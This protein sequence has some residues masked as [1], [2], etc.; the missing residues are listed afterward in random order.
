M[1]NTFFEKSYTKCDG[2]TIPRPFSKKSKSSISR[3]QNSKVWY[4]LFLCMPSWGLSEHSET[5]LQTTC[6]YLPHIW[7]VFNVG[8]SPF[9][10]ICVIRLIESPLK[11]IKNAFYFTLKALFILKIFK[12]LS[13]L[14]GHISKWLD[15]QYAYW[16]CL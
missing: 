6:F 3:D 10:N 8:L 11:M 4:S 9:K 12:F 16:N 2:D 15:Y 5:K 13:W 14:F 7:S 1:R